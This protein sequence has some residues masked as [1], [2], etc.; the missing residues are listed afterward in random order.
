MVHTPGSVSLRFGNALLSSDTLF[1]RS[2]GRPDLEDDDEAAI[3]RAA[4]RLFAT[5]REIADMSDETL[6]LPNH[7]GNETDRPLVATL[8]ELRTTN[9]LLAIDSEAAVVERVVEG[10]GETP[11]NYRRIKRVNW[12]LEPLG[13][14]TARLE[15]GPNN[16]AAN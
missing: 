9:D 1:V 6:V 3:R 11:A 2:V 13:E 4:A 15:F 10:L 14:E 12:G 5:L 7:F 8:G 16:C